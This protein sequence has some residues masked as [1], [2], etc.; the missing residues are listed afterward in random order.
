MISAVERGLPAKAHSSFDGQR[1]CRVASTHAIV[2]WP[3]STPPFR[4]IG[5]R[6]WPL[7]LFWTHVLASVS[8]SA[9]A[10]REASRE[11][12][13]LTKSPRPSERGERCCASWIAP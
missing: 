4:M 7:L 13:R 2:D 8:L 6:S 3:L 5:G 10:K 12:L 1:D 11:R 9:L